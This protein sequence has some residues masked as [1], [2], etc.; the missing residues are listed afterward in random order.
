MEGTGQ[1]WYLPLAW[2]RA[3]T[4]LTALG[5]LLAFL[6]LMWKTPWHVSFDFHH[7]AL[8]L[9]FI[10]SSMVLTYLDTCII[11][12]TLLMPIAVDTVLN[13][14]YARRS[15]EVFADLKLT[16]LYDHSFAER[17]LLV[18]GLVVGPIVGLLPASLGDLTLVYMC[19]IRCQFI[20]L[21]GGILTSL[22]RW[23]KQYWGGLGTTVCLVGHI[24]SQIMALYY[25]NAMAA[26]GAG[27]SNLW[28]TLI[29]IEGV[30]AFI[31]FVMTC[32]WVI[33]LVQVGGAIGPR[34]TGAIAHIHARHPPF[35]TPLWSRRQ[36]HA[37]RWRPRRRG[38]CFTPPGCPT[39]QAVALQHPATPTILREMFSG[40]AATAAA[41]STQDL[42]SLQAGIVGS[43]TQQ[44]AAK[45]LFSLA[46][47]VSIMIYLFVYNMKTKG[48]DDV[49]GIN[50]AVVA[51]EF[52]WL[53]YLL[54]KSKMDMLQVSPH[55]SY[56][57]PCLAP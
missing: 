14:V 3:H 6:P 9:G 55:S 34:G 2:N 36:G 23:N 1:Q 51:V 4:I 53:V 17:M 43:V 46:V 11:A 44:G 54:Q 16:S 50:V 35:T 52:L 10:D 56:S 41:P 25:D 48:A 40:A 26:G 33:A 20:L 15:A 32:R 39:H 18:V 30:S 28:V 5:G 29:A 47:F 31:F 13:I 45:L 38:K 42:Q 7:L 37:Q 21:V 12:L 24:V 19:C 49:I 57:A 8:P 27:S 22:S